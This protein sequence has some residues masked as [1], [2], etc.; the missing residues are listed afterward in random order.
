MFQTH[1]DWVSKY[2]FLGIFGA[3]VCTFSPPHWK[4]T[5]FGIAPFNHRQTRYSNTL[6]SAFFGAAVCVCSVRHTRNT[7]NQP[8][9]DTAWFKHT[10]TWYPNTF[11]VKR[12]VR[13]VRHTGNMHFW[14]HTFQTHP[15]Q[16][17]KGTVVGTYGAE[18]CACHTN[19]N[20][21]H[22]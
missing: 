9:N 14:H 4:H 13:S 12:Y 7:P 10:P 1:A 8:T 6:W 21:G 18:I 17:S 3:Q 16:V 20:S 15:L 11:F 2:T 5:L 22:F 19:L